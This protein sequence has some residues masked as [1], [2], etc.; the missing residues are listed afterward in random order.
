MVSA[1]DLT[2]LNAAA[3]S[4]YSA[5]GL[6]IEDETRQSIESYILA[7]PKK[8]HNIVRK[9]RS[10][11]L[12][13]FS[14][15]E[16]ERYAPTWSVDLSDGRTIKSMQ[17]EQLLALPNG[18]AAR[19]V[20]IR[21]SA[22]GKVEN[23]GIRFST[24]TG[25]GHEFGKFS[26]SIEG[27]DEHVAVISQSLREYLDAIDS[28]FPKF[29][30]YRMPFVLPW[31]IIFALMSYLLV[32]NLAP[33]K[34]KTFITFFSWT[35]G[36]VPAVIADELMIKFW[37]RLYRGLEVD[38]GEGSRRIN[39]QKETRSNIGYGLIGATALS[40]VIGLFFLWLN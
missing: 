40:F 4:A 20:A 19:V 16:L 25:Q 35:M 7:L 18:R 15:R 26:A 31:F 3:F 6:A 30:K 10:A 34:D 39:D 32:E 17:L 22:G 33:P 38:I 37:R 8:S 9:E 13:N 12:K 14:D 23:G 29:L 24:F 21:L 5:C 28:D 2:M 27:K 36:L 1:A 11:F